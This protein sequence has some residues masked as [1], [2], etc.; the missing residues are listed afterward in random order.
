MEDMA[1][2]QGQQARLTELGEDALVDIVSDA[3]RIHMRRVVDRLLAEE[4]QAMAA[5]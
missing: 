5:E 3:A 1:V 4:H 2:V